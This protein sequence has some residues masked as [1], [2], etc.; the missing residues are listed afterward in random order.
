MQTADLYN[1]T[2]KS[3]N[4]PHIFAIADQAYHSMLRA[5]KDQ[6]AVIRSACEGDIDSDVHGVLYGI[7]RLAV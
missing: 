1:D 2:V 3:A 4:P 7:V 6:C 5:G